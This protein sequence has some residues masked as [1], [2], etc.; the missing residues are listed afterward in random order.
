LLG[1]RSA[2]VAAGATEAQAGVGHFLREMRIFLVPAT[3]R[4]NDIQRCVKA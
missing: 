3:K 1:N 2:T 4:V